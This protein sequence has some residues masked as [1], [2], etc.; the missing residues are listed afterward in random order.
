[1]EIYKYRSTTACIKAAFDLMG[2]H[3]WSLVKKTWWAML[4]FAFLT[5]LT[6]YFRLPNKA[7]HDWGVSNP[8]SSWA[9]Q[10]AV[11][12]L[13]FVSSV[14]AGA[15]TWS[16]INKKTVWKNFLPYLVFNILITFISSIIMLAALRAG[17]LVATAGNMLWVGPLAVLAGLI[18][19]LVLIM[20]F[21]FLLPRLMLLQKGEK[22][23]AWK[24]Y[25]TGLHHLGGIFTA[26]ILCTLIT[27]IVSCIIMLPVLILC[28]AQT[29]S[30]LGALDGDPLGVPASFTPLLFAVSTLVFFLLSYICMWTGIVFVYLYGSYE[31][32]EKEKQQLKEQQDTL[33]TRK[34]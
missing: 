12:L 27:C 31:T 11:Y 20:P 34:Q 29:M 4:I 8:L 30:Q 28:G 18:V 19:N 23:Q 7:L 2:N 14:L 16:W 26:G 22:L 6:L 32:Q 33:T 1:M 13:S 5:T 9:L 25:K 24:S 10:S 15:A 17:N 3:L 21:A